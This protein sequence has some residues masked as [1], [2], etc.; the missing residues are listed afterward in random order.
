MNGHRDGWT[1]VRNQQ[2]GTNVYSGSYDAHHR[3]NTSGNG[4]VFHGKLKGPKG[5]A[6]PFYFTDVCEARAKK[7]PSCN[8]T[9]LTGEYI[10]KQRL[11]AKPHNSTNEAS[12][13]FRMKADETPGSFE[14]IWSDYVGGS[15]K[16]RKKVKRAKAK[17]LKT[18]VEEESPHQTKIISIEETLAMAQNQM[19]AM[20]RLNEAKGRSTER[21][22][23][24]LDA[25]SVA[26]ESS[27]RR[28]YADKLIDNTF[29]K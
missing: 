3:Q 28:L 13:R 27:V 5:K 16:S 4:G 19:D 25:G 23:R 12:K 17:V 15:L 21:F 26:Y 1:N 29:F 9:M 18:E 8:D 14:T 6:R 10:P 24:Y 7:L 11:R 20:E 2:T 22:G